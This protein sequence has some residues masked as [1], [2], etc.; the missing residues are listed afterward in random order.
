MSPVKF[1]SPEL[2][3][4]DLIQFAGHIGGYQRVATVL[5]VSM[6]QFSDDFLRENLAFRDGAD[7]FD[8]KRAFQM[9]KDTFIERMPGRRISPFF[10]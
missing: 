7:R 2:T 10:S 3:A 4:V 6:E 9:V 1:S 8:P 5:A